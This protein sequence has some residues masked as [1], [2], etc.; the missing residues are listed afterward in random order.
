MLSSVQ[1]RM[2][3]VAVCEKAKQGKHEH[4]QKRDYCLGNF[5]YKARFDNDAN[6]K[7]YC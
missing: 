4:G 5:R 2:Q 6:C 3:N 1:S 7:P